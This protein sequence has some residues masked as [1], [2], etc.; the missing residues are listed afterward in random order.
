[1]GEAAAPFVAAAL[2]ALPGAPTALPSFLEGEDVLTGL[3]RQYLQALLRAERHEASRLIL[4]AVRAGLGVHDL[5]LLCFQRCER[6]VGRLW[7]LRQVTVAQEHYCTAATQLVM[8]QLYPYLFA[9]PKKGR[10]LVAASV[11]GELHEVGL[12]IVTDLF[13]ADGWDTLYLGANLPAGGVVQAIERHRPDL[14]LVSATMAFH[15]A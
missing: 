1:M 2:R 4:D 12:R 13:E 9:L 6:E 5:Y 14:L 15:L 11:G 10:R 8:S 3:A 7:Q